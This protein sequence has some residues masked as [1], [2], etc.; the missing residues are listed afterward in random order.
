MGALYAC[1]HR[2]E[3]ALSINGCHP[4]AVHAMAKAELALGCVDPFAIRMRDSY[5]I[6][7]PLIPSVH[8]PSPSA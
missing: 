5:V 4:K 8:T 7:R 2:A 1:V 6:P 3:G